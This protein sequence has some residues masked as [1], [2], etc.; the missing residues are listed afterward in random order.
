MK[1]KTPFTGFNLTYFENPCVLLLDFIISQ[2]LLWSVLVYFVE[3]WLD[4]N[5]TVKQIKIDF[6]FHEPFIYLQ[7]SRRGN[8]DTFTFCSYLLYLF[9][10]QSTLFL[11]FYLPSVL[12]SEGS[13]D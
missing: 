5:V 11:F 13:S 2:K 10:N 1:I 9:S 7:Q 6:G 4:P 8:E 3:Q 12:A